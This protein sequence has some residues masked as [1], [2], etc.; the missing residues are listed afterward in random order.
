[1]GGQIVGPA[2]RAA[3]GRGRRIVLMDRR[4]ACVQAENAFGR[5]V[6][7][8][9]NPFEVTIARRTAPLPRHRCSTIAPFVPWPADEALVAQRARQAGFEQEVLDR[10]GRGPEAF[11]ARREL[12]QHPVADAAAVVPRRLA[13]STSARRRSSAR[14][15]RDSEHRAAR[16]LRAHADDGAARRT[17]PRRCALSSQ[18][19]R[20]N[21]RRR[22]AAPGVAGLSCPQSEASSVTTGWG[23]A[24]HPWPASA[25]AS[26]P[27][28]RQAPCGLRGAKL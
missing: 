5:A 13:S 11:A 17:L 1:M 15:L 25:E 12:G 16:G 26:H 23:T 27:R 20:R 8:G 3:S 14:G 10:I 19:I 2:R 24:G 7:A 22:L 6:L 4:P 21:S 28:R 18:I 9:E